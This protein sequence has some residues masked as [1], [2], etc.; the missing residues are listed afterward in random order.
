MKKIFLFILLFVCNLNGYSQGCSEDNPIACLCPGGV[1]TCDLLPD[2]KVTKAILLEAGLNPETKGELRIST[3]TPNL[4]YGPLS[5]DATDYYVCG[6]DTIY[7]PLINL[8][9]CDDGTDPHQLIR[10]RIFRKEGNTIV[11]YKRWAGSMTYHPIHGHMHVDDWCAFQLRRSVDGISDPFEMPIVAAGRKLGFCL[12]D[13]GSCDDYPG[14]CKDANDSTVTGNTAINFGLGGGEYACGTIGQGISAGF[15]DI[16]HHYLDDMDIQI[17]DSLCN[18]KYYLTVE[19]DPNNNFIETDETNNKMA[20][21]VELKNQNIVPTKIVSVSDKTSICEN[22]SVNLSAINALSY[23][24]NTGETTQSI[25]VSKAGDYVVTIQNS[26]E[27]IVSTPTSI[28]VLASLPTQITPD[29]TICQATQLTLSAQGSGEISWYDALDENSQ[30]IGTGNTFITPTINANKTYYLNQKVVYPGAIYFNQ[31][32]DNT[33]GDGGFS[34]FLSWLNFDVAS[35]CQLKS[36]KV[37]SG[38]AINT[39]I[40]VRA[41]DGTVL[42]EKNVDI[43]EGESRLELN[44]NLQPGTNYQL[45]PDEAVKLF[46]NNGN[47]TYPYQISGII[48]INGSNWD[49]PEN[50][51]YRYYYFYDWEIT[52]PDRICISP[53]IP[54]NVTFQDCV[55]VNPTQKPT[56]DIISISPNPNNGVFSVYL[57]T[58]QPDFIKVAIFDIT[59]KIVYSRKMVVGTNEF[60]QTIQVNELPKASYILQITTSNKTLTQKIDIQ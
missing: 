39:N 56:T 57:K 1:D 54:V 7:S 49:D 36:V 58:T 53:K 25:A 16:Y 26:C 44:F 21:I 55:G 30:P 47:V 52:E 33:F 22:S 37:F 18:G 17:P 29:T 48:S 34:N 13:Y 59:G 2:L 60:N 3:A 35:N 41:S 8:T 50:D 31:P 14:Y 38:E 5:V 42:L 27:S 45:G 10:Q 43:P 20:V 32:H 23:Q 24:W 15:L 4:G 6:T 28:E 19:V 40:Q 51:S 46:R 11:K 9:T 12:M